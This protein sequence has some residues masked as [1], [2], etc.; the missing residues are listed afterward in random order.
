MSA[1]DGGTVPRRD[2]NRN[3][4]PKPGR[5]RAFASY[6][7]CLMVVTFVS[8]PTSRRRPG[9]AARRH[10]AAVTRARRLHQV[11]RLLEKRDGE[12]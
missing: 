1:K 9:N 3:S 4:R 7:W 2:W 6:D 5:N 11:L 8:S 10:A 12:C